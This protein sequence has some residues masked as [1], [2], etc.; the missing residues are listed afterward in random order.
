M[1]KFKF[2][3]DYETKKNNSK[4]NRLHTEPKINLL[5]NPN[6]PELLCYPMP[7]LLVAPKFF[8]TSLNVVIFINIDRANFLSVGKRVYMSCYKLVALQIVY[9]D[10]TH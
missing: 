10:L 5:I 7:E 3:E 9:S 2:H 8:K 6:M 4:K 1:T